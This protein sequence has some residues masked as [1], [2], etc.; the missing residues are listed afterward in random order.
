MSKILL[1]EDDLNTRAGLAEI[2]TEEGY[3]VVLA[4]DAA[5]ALEEIDSSTDLMLSDFEL[6]GLTGLDLFRHVKQR[7]PGLISIMMTAYDPSEHSLY[8]RELGVHSF[9]GKPLNIE[10]LLSILKDALR[11]GEALR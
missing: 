11:Q 8:A 9:L 5:R 7:Y 1:V 2:L 4:E 6:P 10:G 3:E